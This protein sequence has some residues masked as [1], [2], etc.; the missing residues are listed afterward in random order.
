M[1]INDSMVQWFLK[2][3]PAI[4]SPEAGNHPKPVNVSVLIIN[5]DWSKT[6]CEFQSG[7]YSPLRWERSERMIYGLFGLGYY[8]AN[9]C[10]AGK[11]TEEEINIKFMLIDTVCFILFSRQLPAR[12]ETRRNMDTATYVFSI[13]IY[14]AQIWELKMELHSNLI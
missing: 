12:W 7:C 4:G 5:A 8:L 6:I 11:L 14:G 1:K 10:R 3:E 9:C 2:Y 13:Y